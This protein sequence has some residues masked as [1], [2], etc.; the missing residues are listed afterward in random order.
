MIEDP[1]D[2]DDEVDF[3][4]DDFM[5]PHDIVADQFRA[6]TENLRE[7]GFRFTDIMRGMSLATYEITIE[8]QDGADNL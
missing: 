5:E 1:E 6:M 3:D 7:E 8:L 2:D 4:A